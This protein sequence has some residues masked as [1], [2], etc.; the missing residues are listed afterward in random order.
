[1]TDIRRRDR[2]IAASEAWAILRGGEYG[3]LSLASKE[4]LPYGIPLSFCLIDDDLYFH[5]A[6]EGRKLDILAGNPA[7]SFC[8][9]GPTEV[10]PAKFGT[11]YES[12]IASGRAHEVFDA[13]KQKGLEGLL[14]KYAPDHFESGLKYIESL[15]ART[16][17]F[18]VVI[19][20]VSCKARR[21]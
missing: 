19:E 3:V 4:G 1:M 7:V 5:C 17:V 15:A 16:R 21:S 13:E 18:K 14:H 8:V 12:A 6:V 11:Q 2:E 9:V 10:M 20:R